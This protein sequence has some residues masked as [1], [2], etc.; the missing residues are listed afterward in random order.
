MNAVYE[1]RPICI[2]EWLPDRCMSIKEPLEIHNLIP[3]HGCPNLLFDKSQIRDRTGFE[4]FYHDVLNRFTCCGFIAWEKDRIIGYTN[5]FPHEIARKIKF[6]GWGETEEEQPDTLIHHCI[7][8]VRNPDYRHIGIGSSL[9]RHSLEWAKTNQWRRYEVHHVL[10]DIDKGTV[11][12]QK[13]VLSFWKKFGFSIIGE[14]EADE[15]TRKYYGVNK[16]Y[17][18]A[19]DIN[20]S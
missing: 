1:I 9:I 8:I 7:S 20:H 5:F 4:A 11:S 14:E 10:P 2:E 12:E 19:L 18:L 3:Q 6:Y 17:S 15:K 13:S 16:R